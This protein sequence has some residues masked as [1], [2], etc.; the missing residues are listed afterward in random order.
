MEQHY[1]DPLSL[2]LVAAKAHLSPNYFSQLFHEIVGVAFQE[3]LQI[4]RVRFARSLLRATDMSVT[5]I[6]YASGFR[7]LSHFERTFKEEYGTSPSACRRD[8]RRVPEHG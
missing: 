8:A 3:H 1:R 4:L 6:C 5:D 2:E 7:T